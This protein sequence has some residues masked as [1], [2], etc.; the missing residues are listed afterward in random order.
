MD[1][2]SPIAGLPFVES[3][4]G[5]PQLQQQWQVIAQPECRHERTHLHQSLCY[6]FVIIPTWRPSFD[7]WIELIPLPFARKSTHVYE[8][9][10]LHA[11]W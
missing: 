8:K 9:E 10:R 6:F 11:E 3:S 1:G 5:T 7:T 2:H 4:N